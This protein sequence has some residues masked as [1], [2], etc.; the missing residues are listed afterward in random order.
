MD[1]KTRRVTITVVD[2][3]NLTPSEWDARDK[4][5]E[6]WRQHMAKLLNQRAKKLA[7]E[8]TPSEFYDRLSR[9]A[10]EMGFGENHVVVKV[11]EQV[12]G[13]ELIFDRWQAA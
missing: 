11:T 3:I 8:S 2:D 10:Y 6:G 5:T 7:P 9:F 4:G 1:I 13:V 12:Y